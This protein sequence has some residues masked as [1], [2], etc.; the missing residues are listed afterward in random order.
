VTIQAGVTNIVAEIIILTR[1]PTAFQ[2]QQAEQAWTSVLELLKA[3]IHV[4]SIP[5]D[6]PYTQA[7]D[8]E[9]FDIEQFNTMLTA[10][11][12]C[13]TPELCDTFRLA[14]RIFTLISHGSQLYLPVARPNVMANTTHT[15]IPSCIPPTIHGTTAQA[16]A[17]QRERAAMICFGHLFNFCKMQ[18]SG[19]SFIG[20]SLPH[21]N[22]V[23]Q[24]P[25]LF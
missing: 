12:D 5:T 20:L 7:F 9:T 22:Q 24:Q 8:D 15:A 19:G 10:L 18:S 3:V 4:E 11:L 25:V 6:I 13:I 23:K 21:T 16:V 17:V 14:E 2:D 1:T